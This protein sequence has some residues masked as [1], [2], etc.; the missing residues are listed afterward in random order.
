MKDMLHKD[1]AI[2]NCSTDQDEYTDENCG[3]TQECDLGSQVNQ[4]RLR[5]R[6]RFK[7]RLKRLGH[8]VIDIGLD[9]VK[10]ALGDFV[11]GL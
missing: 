6:D 4:G 9:P 1:W 3:T 8:F 10:E 2:R 5:K 11:G 7:A